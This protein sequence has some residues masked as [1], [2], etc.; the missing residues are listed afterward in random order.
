[1]GGGIACEVQG[2]C[3]FVMVL[4]VSASSFANQQVFGFFS[5]NFL[6]TDDQMQN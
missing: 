5:L 6:R 4:M 1:M 3:C 2:V